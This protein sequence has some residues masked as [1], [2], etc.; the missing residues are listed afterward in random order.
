MLKIAGLLALSFMFPVI[1]LA[2]ALD[3][4]AIIARSAPV[5]IVFDQ[6]FEQERGRQL[7]LHFSIVVPTSPEEVLIKGK[8]DGDAAYGSLFFY[9]PEQQLAEYL[10]LSQVTIQQGTPEQRVEYLA[11]AFRA[12]ILP[13]YEGF[14][15]FTNL[16]IREARIA[17]YPAVEMVG[18]YMDEKYGRIILRTI[19]IFAPSGGRV[20]IAKSRTVL[21]GIPVE[22]V[23]GMSETFVGQVL[24]SVKFIGTRNNGDLFTF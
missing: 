19:G 3:Y 8:F 17:G 9:T 16:G 15:E 24:E 14:D 7:P 18:H 6:S 21:A 13:D 10:N 12:Q 23:N 20:L 2:Q 1:A 22:N 11:N 4:K 5:S